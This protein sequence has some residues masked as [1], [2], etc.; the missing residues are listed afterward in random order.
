MRQREKRPEQSWTE[1]NSAQRVNSIKGACG[2]RVWPGYCKAV[3]PE[4]GEKHAK[5]RAHFLSTLT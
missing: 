2:F 5:I 1:Q 3:K 4:Y